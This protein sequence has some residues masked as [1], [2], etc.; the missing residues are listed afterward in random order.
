MYCLVVL[1]LAEF[2]RAELLWAKLPL[3]DFGSLGINWPKLALVNLHLLAL[4]FVI[5]IEI[6]YDSLLHSSGNIITLTKALILISQ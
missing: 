4:V 2:E 6:K 5:F 1:L 3:I